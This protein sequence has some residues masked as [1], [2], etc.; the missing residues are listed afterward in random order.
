MLSRARLWL[1]AL[2]AV[3][4]SVTADLD[5]LKENADA[6]AGGGTAGTAGDAG[7]AVCEKGIACTGCIEC[8]AFC[9]CAAPAAFLDKCLA[10]CKEA[11]VGGSGGSAGTAGTA[12]SAG[13]A[14][15]GGGN[16]C[17]AAWFGKKCDTPSFGV[18]ECDA[19][20]VA[21]CCSEMDTCLAAESCARSVYCI[22]QECVGAPSLAVCTQ[23]K[24]TSCLPISGPAQG[25][26]D[27]AQTKCANECPL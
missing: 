3:A 16:S 12:G 2:V 27:C 7:V 8:E 18:A 17:L 23:Q 24:C 22:A 5:A 4:C 13:A 21:S 10:D 6:S 20:L 26:F 25:L 9:N 19:C 1:P 11:G 15:S 14:G